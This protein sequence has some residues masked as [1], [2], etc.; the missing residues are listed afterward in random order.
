MNVIQKTTIGLASIVALAV[1]AL[2]QVNADR[3]PVAGAVVAQNVM[4]LNSPETPQ[5]Q[6]WDMIYG[7]LTPPSWVTEAASR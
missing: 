7:D 2:P 1:F 6:Q 5:A 4:P 3:A